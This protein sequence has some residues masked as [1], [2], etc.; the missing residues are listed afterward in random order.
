MVGVLVDVA[1]WRNW[2]AKRSPHAVVVNAGRHYKD[3]NFMAVEFPGRQHLYLHRRVGFAV[4][5]LSD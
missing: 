3:E 2:C 1:D 5:L 4:A